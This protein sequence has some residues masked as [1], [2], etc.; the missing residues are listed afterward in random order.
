MI[1]AAGKTIGYRH[2]HNSVD[3]VPFEVSHNLPQS[4]LPFSQQVDAGYLQSL[5]KR[6]TS[7]T[8]KQLCDWVREERGIIISTTAMCRLVKG[9]N[10]QRQRS[11]RQHIYPRRSLALAA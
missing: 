4:P 11:Q 1:S 7:C 3:E 6:D 8:L 9:Y 10:L 2:G 5:I